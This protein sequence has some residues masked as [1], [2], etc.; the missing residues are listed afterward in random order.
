MNLQLSKEQLEYLQIICKLQQKIKCSFKEWFEFIFP[1]IEGKK[2]IHQ[3]AVILQYL[4][5]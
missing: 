2:L 3:E 4:R 5:H 1:I